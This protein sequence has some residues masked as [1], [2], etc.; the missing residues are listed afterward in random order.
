MV[1]VTTSGP[2]LAYNSNDHTALVVIVT[3]FFCLLMVMVMVA[4][5]FIRRNIGVPLQDFDVVLFLAAS[6]MVAQTICIICASDPGI[7]RHLTDVSDVDTVKK[8]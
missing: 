7:G 5:I 4:K 2:F 3:V 6:L 8:V 1:N